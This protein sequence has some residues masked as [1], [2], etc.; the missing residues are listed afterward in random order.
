[1]IDLM[2]KLFTYEPC[3][4]VSGN[5]KEYIDKVLRGDIAIDTVVTNKEYAMYDELFRGF[6]TKK[7]ISKR[8]FFKGFRNNLEN[9][10]EIFAEQIGE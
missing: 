7:P 3:E 9:F 10:K 5:E 8:E 4:K 6:L 1:M 2:L